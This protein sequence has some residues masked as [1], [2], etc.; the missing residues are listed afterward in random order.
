MLR[1]RGPPMQRLMCT[2]AMLIA[3]FRFCIRQGCRPSHRA[4]PGVLEERHK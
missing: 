1:R 3:W 2:A 4:K